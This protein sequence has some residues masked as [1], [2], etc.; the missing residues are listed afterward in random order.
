MALFEKMKDSL[1]IAGQEVAQKT[2]NATEGVRISN[3]IKANERMIEKLTYQVG[4][5]CV[6][7]HMQ[8]T[9]SEYESLFAEIRRLRSENQVYQEEL[10]RATAVKVCPQCGVGNKMTSKFCIGCG[11]PLPAQEAEGPAGGKRCPK[12]GT[13]NDEDASFCVECGTPMPA[14]EKPAVEKPEMP[15]PGAEIMG[16]GPAPEIQEPMVEEALAPEAPEAPAAGY[17]CR[18]CGTPLEDDMLFCIN[19]GTKRE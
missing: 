16:D 19:C 12:C 14:V 18:N 15:Q 2:K 10:R 17:T 8:E 4:L 1:T 6:K 9:G 5:Q 7:N 3:L 13:M 11:A